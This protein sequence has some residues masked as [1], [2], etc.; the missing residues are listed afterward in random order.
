MIGQDESRRETGKR[1]G[2][3]TTWPNLVLI[4]RKEFPGENWAGLLATSSKSFFPSP[5]AT[6]TTLLSPTLSTTV[7]NA[8][9]N[10]AGRAGNEIHARQPVA[11]HRRNLPANGKTVGRIP[12]FTVRE[13]IGSLGIKLENRPKITLA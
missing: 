5:L 4:R 8:D 3:E 2:E 9:N 1:G 12:A 6:L 10:A 11:G 7:F 13:Y